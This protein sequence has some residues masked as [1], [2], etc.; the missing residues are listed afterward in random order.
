MNRATSF[1]VQTKDDRPHD[2]LSTIAEIKRL[3]NGFQDIEAQM[4]EKAGVI[5]HV[6]TPEGVRKYNRPI[7]AVIVANGNKNTQLTH[8]WST[9]TTSEDGYTL[10]SGASNAKKKAGGK[11]APTKYW[12]GQ[13]NGKGKWKVYDEDLTE[14]H[15]G[16]DE[17]EVVTWLE[18]REAKKAVGRTSR[19]NVQ[20]SNVRKQ[21]T[22]PVRGSREPSPGHHLA[23]GQE[24]LDYGLQNLNLVDIMIRDD[25]DDSTVYIGKGWDRFDNSS[26]TPFARR[27][28]KVKQAADKADTID[29]MTKKMAS[30]E[31]KTKK[32]S[33]AG[34][35]TA[36]AVLLMRTLAPRVGGEKGS[37]TKGVTTFTVGDVEFGETSDG[38][39]GAWI[40]FEAKNGDTELGVD[41][42]YIV[43]MLERAVEGK[44]PGDKLFDTTPQD[45]GAYI[46]DHFGGTLEHPNH[47]M[48]TYRATEGA[49]DKI[50]EIRARD[51]VPTTKKEWMAQADEVKAY[52]ASEVLH[53]LEPQ[54]FKSYVHPTVLS[55]LG[56][57][58]EWLKAFIATWEKGQGR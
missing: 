58:P 29:A 40:V 41:D 17:Y 55:E 50:K 39:R 33:D 24:L 57:D 27:A 46:Q 23:T 36:M 12:V 20:R 7:G 48:R 42:P 14:I 16:P 43:D 4:E 5:R 56:G 9:G 37:T 10:Y 8:I 1:D 15:V 54:V 18:A 44:E 52:V 32:L 19:G 30:F 28:G 13:D 51:E 6:R 21:R 31:R 35:E 2:A 34:D 47:K 11:N 49:R 38:K 25:I 3:L 53:D 45:T 26:Q 22:T